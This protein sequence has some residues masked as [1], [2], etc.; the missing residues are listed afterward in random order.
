MEESFYLFRFTFEYDFVHFTMKVSSTFHYFFA[1]NDQM[2]RSNRVPTTTVGHIEQDW[3]SF[4][5]L[6]VLGTLNISFLSSSH[7]SKVLFPPTYP[8]PSVPFPQ[9]RSQRSPTNFL[10]QKVFWPSASTFSLIFSICYCSMASL[11][12]QVCVKNRKK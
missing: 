2:P 10:F 1:H 8:L 11:N 12:F 6:L 7:P 5:F 9:S 4:Y 3:I